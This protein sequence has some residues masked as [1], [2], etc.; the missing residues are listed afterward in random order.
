MGIV[1]TSHQRCSVKRAVLQNLQ[2][3]PENT[4]VG[5]SLYCSFIKNRLQHRCFPVNIVNFLRILILKNICDRMLLYCT[6]KNTKTSTAN[7]AKSI[8]STIRLVMNMVKRKNT[9][10]VQFQIM[11]DVCNYICMRLLSKNLF[12][13]A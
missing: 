12:G 13:R 1:R 6:K 5:V 11:L 3:S 4:C 8:T 7:T 9:I 2:Y 10:W